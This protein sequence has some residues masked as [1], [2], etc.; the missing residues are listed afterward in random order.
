MKQINLK[1]K[2]GRK[3]LHS[4]EFAIPEDFSELTLKKYIDWVSVVRDEELQPIARAVQL[5][6]AICGESVEEIE[7]LSKPTFEKLFELIEPT[8]KDGFPLINED[9]IV[10][11]KG[12][13]KLRIGKEIFYWNPDYFQDS[14]GN[15][16]RMEKFLQGKDLFLHFHYVL[17]FC[18]H[19]KDEEF[20]VDALNEKA[21]LFA[22]NI[23]MDQVHEMVFFSSKSSASLE[24]F[25]KNFGLHL[26]AREVVK[27]MLI[28]AE[29]GVD[30]MSE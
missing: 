13:L 6:A 29:G 22:N 11:P 30:M 17:A 5:V 21:M 25:L 24:L 12:K 16:Q 28:S 9:E 10:P 7:K 23:T 19:R 3:V 8:L 27:K 4:K 15:V 20:D 18:A 14:I 1:Y 26:Q 2:Q